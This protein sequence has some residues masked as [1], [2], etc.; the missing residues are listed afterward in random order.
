MP[1]KAAAPAA[2][3]AMDVVPTDLADIPRR[4]TRISSQP[5]YQEETKLEK[6]TKKA[7][8]AVKKPTKKR[9]LD[10]EDEEIAE[11]AE[12]DQS[13]KTKK[14]GCLLNFIHFHNANHTLLGQSGQGGGP[15][16]RPN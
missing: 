16:A 10:D 1:R 3:E 7:K 14:V 9:S 2:A 11:P 4:S 12:E 13:A 8:P 5:G 15:H 6:P